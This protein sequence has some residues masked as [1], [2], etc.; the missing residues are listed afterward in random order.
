MA[1]IDN[2]DELIVFEKKLKEISKAKQNRLLYE[3]FYK[4]FM[5]RFC[6]N[7]NSIEG[8][9]LSLEETCSLLQYDEVRSGHTFTEYQEAKNLNRAIQKMLSVKN[10]TITEKW[11]LESVELITGV[12]SEYRKEDVYVGTMVE[13]VYYPPHF[14]HVPQLMKEYIEKINFSDSSI[15]EILRQSAKL[16]IEFE[17]IHPFQDGNGRTGRLLLNQVLMNHGLLPMIFS[18]PSKYRQAFRIYDKNQDISLML[19]LLIKGECESLRRIKQLEAE[20]NKTI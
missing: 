1:V 10:T 9:T 15:S 6:W 5:Y 8:N 18:N 3:P 20:L 19:H 13:A 12:F 16:H 4:D 11:I 17:R 2:K 7:S 14:E